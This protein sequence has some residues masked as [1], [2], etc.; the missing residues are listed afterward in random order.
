[1]PNL[2]HHPYKMGHQYDRLFNMYNPAFPDVI[3]GFAPGSYGSTDDGM[4]GVD[5]GMAGGMAGGTAG[6]MADGGIDCG[7]PSG[8]LETKYCSYIKDSCSGCTGKPSATKLPECKGLCDCPKAPT[9][10]PPKPKPT[11]PSSQTG[12]FTISKDKGCVDNIGVCSLKAPA[13]EYQDYI[14]AIQEKGGDKTLQTAKQIEDDC[15]NEPTTTAFF[16][17]CGG[18]KRNN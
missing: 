11:T 1:M 17:D 16:Y 4:S 13:T 2:S 8:D 10:T 14:C 3:E 12:S 15:Q 7:K 18:C 9:P 6:R 5:S